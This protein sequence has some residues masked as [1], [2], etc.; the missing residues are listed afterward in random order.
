LT[1]FKLPGLNGLDL[2][3]QIRAANR[4]VPIVLMTA[5]GTAELAIEATRW[6]AYDYLLKPFEMP[7]LLAM[8]ENAVAHYPESKPLEHVNEQTL[9]TLLIGNSRP[10]QVIYKEIGRVAATPATVL[11]RG[12]SGT[13]KELVARAIWRHSERASEPFVA[14]NCTAIP[15]TLVES[16][17]FGHE[18]GAFTGANMRHIGRFERAHGGTIF[19]DE[20]GDM[21]FQT[22]AKLLR[23][24]QDKIIQRIGG[25]DPIS[26][27]VRIITATHC[28]LSVA[29]QE[30]KFREDLFHRLNVIC[31][32]LPA[33]RERTEDI[34]ELV[35]HFLRR[36]SAKMGLETPSIQ[37]DAM[38]FLRRQPWPGNVRELENVICRTLLITPGYV[39]TLG[40]VRSVMSS[41]LAPYE[42]CNH[43]IS[44]LVKEHLASAANGESSEVYD[45]LVGTLERELFKEAIKLSGGN[46]VLAARWL[47]LSRLTL[48]QRLRSLGLRGAP[49][50]PST[51]RLRPGQ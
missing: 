4:F 51:K 11:I 10:M 44:T 5:H 9:S 20:I 38:E 46:Q 14:V 13:G 15:E 45:E 35:R 24:L 39:I 31:I 43:S 2:V 28:D 19:L 8:I 21:P 7:A 6:G 27:D 3:K 25:H 12:E 26:I 33:L 47:G 36:Q 1:D 50:P 23:V 16:E 48:R 30:N 40:D 42:N 18:R 37:S 49:H 22:Q 29:I 17:M 34:P 41:S 32:T